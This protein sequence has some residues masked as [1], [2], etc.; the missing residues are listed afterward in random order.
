MA[1]PAPPRGH[2]RLAALATASVQPHVLQRLPAAPTLWREKILSRRHRRAAERRSHPN[3]G[4]RSPASHSALRPTPKSF[5]KKLKDPTFAAGVDRESVNRGA[6]LIGVEFDQHI[7]N[8]IEAMRG[9]A[10]ELELT[11]G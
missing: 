8:V 4:S 11:R 1:T 6:E 5:K 2:L 10:D 9:I 3:P 7:A